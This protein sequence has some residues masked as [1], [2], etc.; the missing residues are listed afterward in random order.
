MF[1]RW[2]RLMCSKCIDATAGSCTDYV[3][4]Q[5]EPMWR[6]RKDPS[7]LKPRPAKR[8][9]WIMDLETGHSRS[10]GHDS[11]EIRTIV[12][13]LLCMARDGLLRTSLTWKIISNDPNTPLDSTVSME[14]RCDWPF[15]RSSV[16]QWSS[17]FGEGWCWLPHGTSYSQGLDQDSRLTSAIQN[18]AEIEQAKANREARRRKM[19][20]GEKKKLRWSL[21]PEV[22]KLSFRFNSDGKGRFTFYTY[23]YSFTVGGQGPLQSAVRGR[24]GHS[25]F[26]PRC[27]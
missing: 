4:S 6:V 12:D 27:W 23:E 14:I 1:W 25:Y 10:T 2:R 7:V 9:A 5:I 17:A 16:Q 3:Q 19:I 15:F 21:P 18:T 11:V 13:G 8:S 26:C 22:S 20:H 24:I